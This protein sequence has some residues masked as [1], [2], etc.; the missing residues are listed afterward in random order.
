MKDNY[1]IFLDDLRSIG[2]VEL[3]VNKTNDYIVDVVSR[4]II[5]RD[6]DEAVALIKSKGRLPQYISFDNDLG[7]DDFGK[8]KK[9]GRHLVNWI[10]DALLDEKYQLPNNFEFFV[11]SA[12]PVAKDYIQGTMENIIKHIKNN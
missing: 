1:T 3:Y 5:C 6:Y 10:V 8:N 11:H 7:E 2:D 12:N 4:F 9:E